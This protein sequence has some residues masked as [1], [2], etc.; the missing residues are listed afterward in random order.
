[1]GLGEIGSEG[2]NVGSGGDWRVGDDSDYLLELQTDDEHVQSFAGEI[3]TDMGVRKYT[4]SCEFELS[5]NEDSRMGENWGSCH[6]SYFF[7]DPTVLNGD[8]QVMYLFTLNAE[9]YR[10]V[11]DDDITTLRLRNCRVATEGGDGRGV[12]SRGDE[13]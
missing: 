4:V 7:G 10:S 9:T 5:L 11:V 6:L 2:E 3:R 8:D 1:M 12:L 13:D